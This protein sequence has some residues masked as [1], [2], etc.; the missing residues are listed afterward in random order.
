MRRKKAGVP[1]EVTFATKPEIALDQIRT[2]VTENVDRGVVLAVGCGRQEIASAASS[3]M[4]RSN[5][6]MR[7]RSACAP[8]CGVDSS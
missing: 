7:A 1:D 4:I 6:R 3:G 5:V 8:T 2:A